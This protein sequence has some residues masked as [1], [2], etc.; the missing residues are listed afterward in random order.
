[1]LTCR[2]ATAAA[3]GA[4]A[5]SPA[6]SIQSANKC[7]ARGPRSPTCP[8]CHARQKRLARRRVCFPR[9]FDMCWQWVV[10]P[11]WL[12]GTGCLAVLPHRGICALNIRVCWVATNAWCRCQYYKTRQACML[13]RH[14]RPNTMQS[15]SAHV[16]VCLV[17]GTHS[18]SCWCHVH[19]HRKDAATG[20]LK[21]AELLYSTP[22][23]LEAGPWP[24]KLMRRSN[25]CQAHQAAAGRGGG[26]AGGAACARLGRARKTRS[27]PRS[28]PKLPPGEPLRYS[29]GPCMGQSQS[30]TVVPAADSG[31]PGR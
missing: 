22:A 26:T 5:I 28:A 2:A 21:P 18:L 30:L 19:A 9:G 20:T 27:C 12:L 14:A 31:L 8:Y 15:P 10:M 17:V 6:I 16:I 7:S 3:F 25:S 1:M 13:T 24:Q 29:V 4:P 23:P 11:A